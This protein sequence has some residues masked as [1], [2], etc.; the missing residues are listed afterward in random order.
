MCGLEKTTVKASK[1]EYKLDTT[2]EDLFS[3]DW[4]SHK[5]IDVT[6]SK[7]SPFDHY[8]TIGRLEGRQPHPL[9]DPTWYLE[10]NPDVRQAGQEPLNHFMTYGASEGRS[11]HPLFD[12]GWYKTRNRGVPSEH[13][14]PLIHYLQVGEALGFD[15][16]PLFNTQWYRLQQTDPS[17]AHINSICHYLERGYRTGISPHP[18][19]DAKA[20]L[21]DNHDVARA[22]LNPLLHFIRF[23]SREGRNPN[24]HFHSK[25]YLAEYPE[26]ARTGIIPII[27]YINEGAAK[28]YKPNRVFD[29]QYYSAHYNIDRIEAA[30]PL[31][32]FLRH[33][34]QEKLN[35]SPD[36]DAG[37]YSNKYDHESLAREDPL[38][39]YINF[40]Y[41]QGLRTKPLKS[42]SEVAVVFLARSEDGSTAGFDRF[43]RSYRKC[44]AGLDHDLIVIRKGEARKAGARQALD[45]MFG[46][47]GVQYFD[48]DDSG[49]DIHAYLKLA[50]E[51]PHK[52]LC[53]LNSH[54]EIRANDWLAKL[55]EPMRDSQVG[56]AGA[57]ASYESITD[58]ISINS[59][60]VWL[61]NRGELEASQEIINL[62]R[63][64]LENH[65]PAWIANLRSQATASHSQRSRPTLSIDREVEYARY[66]STVTQ[67]GAPLEH[68]AG[69][70]SFPNPHIRTNGFVIQREVLIQFDDD[71][72]L[73]K[74]ACS[75]FESGMHGLPDMLRHLN[76][77]SVLVGADGSIYEKDDWAKSNTFR[78]GNQENVLIWDNR[79]EEF[80]NYGTDDRE[81]VRLLSWGEYAQS[82][83]KAIKDL[84]YDFSKSD[85]ISSSRDLP[86][87]SITSPV[88]ISVAL[89]THNRASLVREALTTIVGQDYP[90]WN[91]TVFDNGS[92]EPL[93]DTVKAFDDDRIRYARSD[94]FLPVTDSWNRAIDL[95]TGDYICLI[96]D[97][98]GFTP[99]SFSNLRNIIDKYKFPD[100]IYSALYQFFHPGVTP[101]EPSGY[102]SRLNY[103]FFFAERFDTFRLDDQLARLAVA[104]SLQYRRNFTFNMQAFF[105][106]QKF[107]SRMRNVTGKV[108]QSP[109]PDYY[110]ANL[111]FGLAGD[112]IVLPKPISIAGVS[113]KSYGFTLFNDL[114]ERGDSLLSTDIRND[115]LYDKFSQYVL[116]GTTY[117]TKYALTM[118][119]VHAALQDS[120]P[121]Q[122][123]IARYRRLQIFKSLGA[124]R[125]L[126]VG[127]GEQKLYHEEVKFLLSPDELAWAEDLIRLGQGYAQGDARFSP[128][129]DQLAANVSMYAPGEQTVRADNR[130]KGDFDSLPSLFSALQS[131]RATW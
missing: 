129:L 83:P 39:H 25:W 31:I 15:P 66:W 28:N 3:A 67:P 105:F 126:V 22:A 110:L 109:F 115:R 40:G 19:F 93:H 78:L 37:W 72:E 68:F 113:R 49:F 112:I 84:G 20:Y 117:D 104:G 74:A 69:F 51:A 88:T 10:Q 13:P 77:R 116:P 85:L 118:E 120:A 127:V 89:P 60:V 122:V 96:G 73:S 91:C 33:G 35:P 100:V 17:I 82:I 76:L 119:H 42:N 5:Y 46:A 54:S 11:P 87:C 56:M 34:I 27:H 130:Y 41:E 71:L 38:L 53:F 63:N 86:R 29:R 50:K 121:S 58:T 4:Y 44:S 65:A 92:S 23:G 61:A 48:V 55:F 101:W 79:V 97:D 30:Q 114:P 24:R 123:N 90:H 2:S 6:S 26:V 95:T 103:G 36:F 108:F 131:G 52:Y 47:D 21:D 64:Q 102:V 111:A 124:V 8:L 107:L 128:P 99:Q 7:L 62:F 14:N 125:G 45:L 70:R 1:M 98:D 12:P 43:A 9:F 75:H 57:T 81:R 18:L 59:K 80:N 32:H 94:D 16:H 106:E